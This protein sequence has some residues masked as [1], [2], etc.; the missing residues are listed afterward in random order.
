MLPMIPLVLSRKQ[1][2]TGVLGRIL[3][4]VKPDSHK[5]A[6]LQLLRWKLE[7]VGRADAV[8]ISRI[9]FLLL[10]RHRSAIPLPA[11]CGSEGEGEAWW[12]PL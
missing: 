3:H 8:G 5:H 6:I 1:R 10:Q 4:F 9:G 7:L 11:G 2:V 12:R